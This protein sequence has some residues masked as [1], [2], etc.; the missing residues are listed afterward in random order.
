MEKIKK[1]IEKKSATPVKP[2]TSTW[3]IIATVVNNDLEFFT[4]TDNRDDSSKKKLETVFSLT[5]DINHADTFK[6]VGQLSSFIKN[7]DTKS[8]FENQLKMKLDNFFVLKV[9]LEN[10]GSLPKNLE[11]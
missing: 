1:S 6:N 2:V 10:L 5:K 4:I 7:A 11:L 9:E 3:F 8:K